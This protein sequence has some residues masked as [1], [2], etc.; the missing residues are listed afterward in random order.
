LAGLAVAD[1]ADLISSSLN[2]CQPA[3]AIVLLA[4]LFVGLF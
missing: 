1:C 2:S 3:A 4:L